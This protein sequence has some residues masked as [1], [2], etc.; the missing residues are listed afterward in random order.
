MTDRG[1]GGS[2]AEFYG[3]IAENLISLRVRGKM[4]QEELAKKAGVSRNVIINIEH[5]KG[6]R[7]DALFKIA[8]VLGVKAGDLCV[9]PTQRDQVS[10]MA[11]MLVEKIMEYLPQ[12]L[13]DEIQKPS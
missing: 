9:S 11:A 13:K 2:L 7:L 10:V 4:S 8:E 3:I 6:C 5:S 12:K 1:C